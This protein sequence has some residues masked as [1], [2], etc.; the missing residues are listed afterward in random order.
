MRQLFVLLYIVFLTGCAGATHMC[1]LEGHPEWEQRRF[2]PSNEKELYGLI[3]PF[4][5]NPL[6]LP[7]S[8]YRYWFERKDGAILLCRQTPPAGNRCG[9]DGWLF[10]NSNG[11]WRVENQWDAMCPI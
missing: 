2:P 1:G 6:F 7:E 11:I 4:F 9:S 5:R 3:K 10:T 8:K